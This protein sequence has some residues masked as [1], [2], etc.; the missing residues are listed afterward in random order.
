MR[1]QFLRTLIALRDGKTVPES[2]M[3]E[4]LIQELLA[5]GV[6]KSINSYQVVSHD[7]YKEFIYDIGLLPELLEHDLAE[8]ED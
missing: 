1:K 6:L 2:Q 4:K 3:S 5:R 8:A 7:A